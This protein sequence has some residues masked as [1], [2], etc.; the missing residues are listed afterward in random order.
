[1][2]R[3]VLISASITVLLGSCSHEE[4]RLCIAD[5]RSSD[6]MHGCCLYINQT[7][8]IDVI[9]LIL[10]GGDQRKAGEFALSSSATVRDSLAFPFYL[11]DELIENSYVTFGEFADVFAGD[12]EKAFPRKHGTSFDQSPEIVQLQTPKLNAPDISSVDDAPWNM[13]VVHPSMND[14]ALYFCSLRVPNSITIGD[15][16]IVLK[17]RDGRVIGAAGLS[18]LLDTLHNDIVYH[19]WL[20]KE[21]IKNSL[22][23]FRVTSK[24]SKYFGRSFSARPGIQKMARREN[25]ATVLEPME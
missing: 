23:T 12:D 7:K 19:F 24:G 20:N 22:V 25:G 9:G 21:L 4:W 6:G 11:G 16:V 18:G 15:V 13:G 17:K 14:D 2:N 5:S 8:P 1:M 3:W 10:V